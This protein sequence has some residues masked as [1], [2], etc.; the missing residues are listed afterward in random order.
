MLGREAIAAIAA[1]VAEAQVASIAAALERVAPRAGPSPAVVATGQG[2]F[3]A[4]RAAAR[5]GLPSSDLSRWLGVDVGIAAPA[6]AVA[7][8]FLD[9]GP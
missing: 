2:A 4:H 9:R 3:L 5:C 8:L 6:V 7:W 1:A